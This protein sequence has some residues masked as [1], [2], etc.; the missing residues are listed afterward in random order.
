MPQ[1]ATVKPLFLRIALPTPLPKLFDYAP[2]TDAISA[3]GS[4]VT[5]PFGPRKLTGVV[6]AHVS[7]AD[8]PANKL[9]TILATLDH[10]PLL[11]AAMLQLLQ[12]AANYYHHPLGEV[13]STALPAALTRGQAASLPTSPQWQITTT[14]KTAQTDALKRA[15]KQAELL[16]ALQQHTISANSAQRNAFIGLEKRGWATRTAILHQPPATTGHTSA[17]RLNDEQT[18]A[19]T[20][21]NTAINQTQGNFQRFLLDGVTGSGKTEVYLQATQ[22]ALNAKR[23]VLVLVPEIGLTPQLIQRFSD[24]LNTTLAVFHSGL[25]NRERLTGWLHARCG[26]AQVIIGTRSAVFTPMK[27]PGLVIVD[28]EHYASFTQQ[29]GLRYSARDLALVR[30]Q[31]LDIPI[32]LGSATP[33]LETLHNAHCGRLTQLHLTQRAGNA[34][35]PTLKLVDIRNQPLQNGLSPQLLTNMRETLARG[36]QV[37]L[38]L[39]R[40]GYAPT[41]ICHACGWQAKC[42]RC[43][44]NLT[45]HRPHA[46]TQNASTHTLSAQL[47]CHH[48]DH[49]RRAPSHCPDCHSVDLLAI[50]HGTARLEE[51]LQQHFPQTELLRI[52]RDVVKTQKQFDQRLAQANDNQSRVLFGTQML[53]KGHHFP[54]VTLVGIVEADQGLYSLDFRAQERLA[55]QIVQVAGRAGRAEK[56][57]T[58]LIQT[59]QP[60]HVLLQTLIR[61]GY[62][63]FAQASLVERQAAGW[64]PF[65][66]LA[67]LRAE[68]SQLAEAMAFLQQAAAIT[69]ITTQNTVQIL[70][71]VAAPM[72]R[73]AGRYRAQLLLRANQRAELHGLLK[74][75]VAQLYTLPGSRKTR[76]SLDV[77]P[78]DL[79]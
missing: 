56:P 24:R 61:Q 69:S 48:C 66:H 49:Q 36:E 3:I 21:I 9:K 52:D 74:I 15:P 17:P 46:T 60:D 23:Q 70:G 41:L 51:T 64:P 68:A 6:V 63:A 76:W 12:W 28:E 5:V 10:T 59:H 33:A 78:A 30:A 57:G 20:A 16:I 72:P 55:Q 54:N 2:Q 29:D 43:D 8:V 14:G 1:N 40:R 50:G 71:P 44:T 25:S 39:N 7:Q 4:R 31:Q 42:Q 45:L 37:L 19:I 67:L 11:N 34:Q 47:H 79:Y 32:I 53:A 27:T 65:A 77:D 18:A 38:F 75:W 73:R 58:V 26:A 22:T 35:P 13:I 62:G